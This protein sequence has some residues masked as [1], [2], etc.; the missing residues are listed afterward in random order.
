MRSKAFIGTLLVAG[1]IVL[2]IGLTLAFSHLSPADKPESIKV[3][4]FSSPLGKNALKEKTAAPMP[5][6]TPTASAISTASSLP[7]VSPAS[8]F[9]PAVGTSAP[10]VSSAPANTA[11]GTGTES[12]MM[13]ASAA[14]PSQ[15]SC[16]WPASAPSAPP[17]VA[18][19]SSAQ[20]LYPTNAAG[21]N[22]PSSQVQVIEFTTTNSGYP[23]ANGPILRSDVPDMSSQP[24]GSN[25][26]I[27][28]PC[29]DPPST[30][31]RAYNRNP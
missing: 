12:N 24:V 26:L 6:A 17:V 15:S 9:S 19:T 8:A 10:T 5:E 21:S 13:G 23:I 20:A 4:S 28:N 25:G 16:S 30:Y 11:N 14:L 7:P 1:G 29:V 3:G 2:G 22:P 27:Q 31:G 18:G